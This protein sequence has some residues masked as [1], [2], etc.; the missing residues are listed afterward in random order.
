MGKTKKRKNQLTN[1]SSPSDPASKRPNNKNNKDVSFSSNDSMSTAAG[2]S[3]TGGSGGITIE[4]LFVVIQS[5]K[6]Q[7]ASLH[8]LISERGDQSE[9]IGLLRSEVASLRAE[10]LALKQ[11]QTLN[12]NNSVAGLVSPPIHYTS[13]LHDYQKN[14]LTNPPS[15]QKEMHDRSEKQYNVVI[16][17][18]QE[19]NPPTPKN[20][21]RA[22]HKVNPEL[23]LMQE[24]MFE[25]GGNPDNIQEVFRMG[26]PRVGGRGR[27][28]KVKCNNGHDQSILLR[29]AR[30]IKGTV[31]GA[32]RLYIRRDQTEFQRAL[33]AAA[34]IALSE[35][36]NRWP[37]KE[38]VL[39]EG[40]NQ[41]LGIYEKR[42]GDLS[43][44]PTVTYF[45]DVFD[46]AAIGN[47]NNEGDENM[48][49]NENHNNNANANV[50]DPNA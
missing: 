47:D 37:N 15:R 43:S 19:H 21:N 9:I 11:G 39:R 24:I 13:K 26:T 20:V 16:C 3:G 23:S 28:I 5:N 31:L 46:T 27:P 45:I 32:E 1:Q 14:C 36:R 34:R 42:G 30:I 44:R 4:S 12:N 8:T 25:A 50:A 6:E 18:L 10:L 7:I 41:S 38:L 48:N 35:A 2:P 17:D 49:G 33:S 40:E 22:N 29:S